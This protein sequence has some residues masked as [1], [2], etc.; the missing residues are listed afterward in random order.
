MPGH[1][2]PTT[3]LQWAVTHLELLEP[4]AVCSC[5][6]IAGISDALA[7][8]MGGHPSEMP[9]EIEV[10]TVWAESLHHPNG[11]PPIGVMRDEL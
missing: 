11:L 3:Q 8:P 5:R 1:R 9:E 6:A 7:S 4:E 2:A 10:D